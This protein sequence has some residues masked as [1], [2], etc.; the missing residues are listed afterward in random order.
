MER[1]TKQEYI[2]N[3][4][5]IKQDKLP[6]YMA[7]YR[8]LAEYEDADEQ[9][10]LLKLPCKVGDTVWYTQEQYGGKTVIK[11]C[12]VSE[13]QIDNWV[14]VY[15]IEDRQNRQMFYAED[16]GKTVFLN[17]EEAEKALLT[18]KLAEVLAQEERRI[19]DERS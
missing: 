1:L 4:P 5:S 8:K 19:K 14:R 12:T 6:S 17:R 3:P 13:I 10:L 7:I 9:G 15:G 16:F 11:S 2:N 18:E